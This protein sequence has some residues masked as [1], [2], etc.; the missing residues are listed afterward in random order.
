MNE[1]IK[2]LYEKALGTDEYGF[3]FDPEKFAELIGRD[4]LK[5][6]NRHGN[7]KEHSINEYFGFE[8]DFGINTNNIKRFVNERTC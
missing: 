7:I 5:L 1:R 8:K 3:K 6:A 2:E 4:M